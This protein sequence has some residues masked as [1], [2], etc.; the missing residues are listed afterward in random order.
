M[1][2]IAPTA[3]AALVVLT[4]IVALRGT[5][6]ADAAC[7]QQAREEFLACKQDCKEDYRSARLTCR[8][9][10]PAC[11]LPCMANRQVCR[12]AYEDVRATGQ[13]PGGGTLDNC[14]SGTDGCR[15]AL[16]DAKTACGAPCN[17]DP[18]CDACVDDAQV[19]SFICRDTC[20]ESWR[21]N[22]TVLAMKDACKSDF[23]ACIEPCPPAN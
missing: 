10:D 2:S 22:P 3:L 14:P 15:A 17:G 6:H 8:N 19:T 5:A 20:R 18:G 9:I 1:R 13:L 12:D 16:E 4:G 21:A 23:Q 11:G 7:K